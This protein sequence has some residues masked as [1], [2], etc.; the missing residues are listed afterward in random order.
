MD[1]CAGGVRRA[2]VWNQAAM[3]DALDRRAY[4]AW[5]RDGQEPVEKTRR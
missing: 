5:G 4:S 3:P 1:W 2:V